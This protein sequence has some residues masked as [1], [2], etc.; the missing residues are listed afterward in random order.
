MLRRRTVPSPLLLLPLLVACGPP[1]LGETNAETGLTGVAVSKGSL[2]GT[3]AAVVETH[4][5]VPI[6]L[7]GDRPGGGKSTRLIRRTWNAAED[8]YQETFVRCTN[9]IFETE[10]VKTV[11]RDETLAKLRPTVYQSEADHPA[12]GWKAVAAVDLMGVKDLPDP[13]ETPLPSDRDYAQAPQS[14]WMFDEDEDGKPGVTVYQ[15]GLVTA[16]L[17][18]CKRSVWSFEGTVVG[19]D[20]ISGIVRQLKNESSAVD[21]SVAWLKGL[22]TSRADPDPLSSWFDMV[23][24]KSGSTCDDVAQALDDGRLSSSRPF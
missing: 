2:A 12:G 5:L 4:T 24:I 21:S 16:T 11:I 14:D 13:V 10:G 22:G 6:P 8:R 19:P 18:V 17:Y 7:A 15:R 23:R 9:D 1:P 3:W 20:R